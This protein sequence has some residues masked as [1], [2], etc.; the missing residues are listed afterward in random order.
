ME[1]C[2]YLGRVVHKRL[3]PFV[4]KFSHRVFYLLLDIDRLD[5]P[6]ARLLSHNRFGLLSLYDRDHGARDGS[7]LRPWVDASLKKAGLDLAGGTVRILCFPRLWGFVFNPL[8]IFFCADREG[9]LRAILYEV[10]NT[11]GD[12]HAYLF[13]VE[14]DDLGPG[15]QSHGCAKTFYVS[16]FIPQAAQYRFQVEEPGERL[17]VLIRESVDDEEILRAGLTGRRAPLSDR[18]LALALVR[19]PLMTLKVIL[20]IHWHA[21]W[22]WLKGAKFHHRPDPPGIDVTV[23]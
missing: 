14:A 2:L 6:G 21:L 23:V 18:T 12:Q 1:G 4:Y 8:S 20:A 13:K 17:S 10:K 3:R 15:L 22:L 16:P 5:E 19:H 9:R 11:F 7:P